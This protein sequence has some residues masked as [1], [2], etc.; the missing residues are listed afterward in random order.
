MSHRTL[1][2]RLVRSAQLLVPLVAVAG[3]PLALPAHAASTTSAHGDVTVSSGAVEVYNDDV[4]PLGNVGGVRITGGG[5]GSSLTPKPGSSKEFYG[6]TDR[7]P[8]VTGPDGNQVEPFPNFVPAIGLFRLESG[9]VAHLVKRIPLRAAN[10]TPYS[11]RVNS[12]NPTGE[13]I[14]DMAG[15]ALP[16]DPN[17]YD[18]EG[19][20]AMKDGTFWVSDEYGPFITHFTANGRAIKRLSPLDGTLPAELVNRVPNKGM[21]GLTITPDGKML[22]G[23]MQSAL[24]Q[25]DLNGSN[26]K[27]LTPTRIVTYTLKTGALHEYLYLLHDP[28]TTGT[29]NSE[30][31]ALSNH[32]FLVDERDGNFATPTSPAFK[33]LYKIDLTGAT[34][35]GPQSTVPG[36]T[37]GPSEGLTIGGSS[38]E[39]LIVGQDTA[40]SRATLAG[41]GIQV[42]SST[43]DVDID[44]VLAAVDP[45]RTLFSHDKM[46]GVAVLDG[47]KTLVIS[48]DSDFGISSAISA[49]GGS[50]TT[51]PYELIAKDDPLTGQQDDGQL[52]VI[53]TGKVHGA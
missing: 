28:A 2:S 22:V 14:E 29:A 10:G 36:S 16:Q 47:G 32:T 46:E 25:P 17:G 40:T 51:A 1:R 7:G 50:A 38:I 6:L 8:N 24:Q 52:L 3:V 26:A 11:G 20:V 30:I 12:A 23:L 15:H 37:Y 5:Y 13:T 18:S 45:S 43:L 21:E 34:D 33:R 53:H 27:K 4:R 44:A 48:N 42:V 9:H 19:L 39:A 41:D 49:A 35:V 31:T